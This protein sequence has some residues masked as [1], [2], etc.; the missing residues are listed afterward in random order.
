MISSP[1]FL[2]E[3]NCFSFWILLRRHLFHFQRPILF[4]FQDFGNTQQNF[5]GHQGK[6]GISVPPVTP[7]EIR[8]LS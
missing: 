7:R 5:K 2:C 1:Y 4:S 3:D 8:A 6:M